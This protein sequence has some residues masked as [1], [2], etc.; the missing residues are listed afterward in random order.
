MWINS[1]QLN[2]KKAVLLQR[3]PHDAAVNYNRYQVCRLVSYFRLFIRRPFQ[4]TNAVFVGWLVRSFVNICSGWISRKWFRDRGSVRQRLR[5]ATSDHLYLFPL[6]DSLPLDVAPS[7]M[8]WSDMER[9]NC[10]NRQR[11]PHLVVLVAAAC[12]LKHVKKFKWLIDRSNEWLGIGVWQIDD[13]TWPY[14]VKVVS[15]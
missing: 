4:I 7:P 6:F 11:H 15:R 10:F 1:G 12:W 14:T 3:K 9:F 8:L 2:N 13:V 5:S